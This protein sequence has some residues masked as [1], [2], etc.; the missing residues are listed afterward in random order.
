MIASRKK[1]GFSLVELS[2]VLLIVAILMFSIIK[3][4]GLIS[5]AKLGVARNKTVSSSVSQMKGLF[6]WLETTSL[7]SFL[8][9]QIVDGGNITA[10]NDISGLNPD[11]P[12]IFTPTGTAPVYIKD[13]IN[14]LPSIRLDGTLKFDDSSLRNIGTKGFAIFTV[15]LRKNGAFQN[16]RDLIFSIQDNLSHNFFTT[17]ESTSQFSALFN[18]LGSSTSKSGTASVLYSPKILVSFRDNSSNLTLRVNGS[19]DATFSGVMDNFSTIDPDNVIF[20]GAGGLLQASYGTPNLYISEIIIFDRALS[21]QEISDIEL[22]LS[23]KYDI[24]IAS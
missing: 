2:V 12:A 11:N 1:L 20:V 5:Q 7:N 6:L 23:D 14:G 15:A 17:L 19:V 4:N 24:S 10:W 21:D 16:S 22:Y 13:S 18:N 9:S 8:T 3:G